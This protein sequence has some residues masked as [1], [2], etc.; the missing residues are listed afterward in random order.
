M[1]RRR[2]LKALGAPLVQVLKPC[3]AVGLRLLR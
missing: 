2:H 1:F 3:R